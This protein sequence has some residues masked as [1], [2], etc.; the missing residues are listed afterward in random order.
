MPEEVFVASTGVIGE[1]LPMEK[2]VD[3]IKKAAKHLDAG[4]YENAAK[5]IMTTD[6]FAK[7][8]S[9]TFIIRW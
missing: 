9:S 3:G 8:I 1:Q 6:T 4:E 5:A 7:S 2:I